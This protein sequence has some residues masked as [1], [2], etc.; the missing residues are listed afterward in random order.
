MSQSRLNSNCDTNILSKFP[1]LG[2]DENIETV[3]GPFNN[4]P[5]WQITIELFSLAAIFRYRQ[6]AFDLLIIQN[7]KDFLYG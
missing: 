5:P 7:I 6:A 4:F 3:F 1:T 2:I